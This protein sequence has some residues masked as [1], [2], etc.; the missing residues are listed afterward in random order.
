MS[1]VTVFC[2]R[3]LAPL[4]DIA[5]TEGAFT[6]CLQCLSAF[7]VEI[8]PAFFRRQSP[9]AEAE[10]VLI[11]GESTCFYHAD[12]K[13]VLPCHGCGRFLCALC[14]CEV[15]DEHFCPSCLEA[16]AAKGKIRSLENRRKRHDSVA[17]TLAL[18]P[19]L[20][21]YITLVTAPATLYVVI[22][23]WKTPLSIVRRT[24]VRFVVAAIIAV[25]QLAGWVVL[26]FILI[27]ALSGRTYL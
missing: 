11:E 4:K 19:M 23:H 16:G 25:L 1:A 2:P 8:F 20:F 13:A 6:R 10:P 12:K 26:I 7:E 3:C 9:A 18:A 24:R 21:F 22:R 5:P 27:V 15:R 14:D 17:L